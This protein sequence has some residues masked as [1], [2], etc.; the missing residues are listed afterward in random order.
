M[1]DILKRLK[2]WESEKYDKRKIYRNTLAGG[3]PIAVRALPPI[4]GIVGSRFDIYKVPVGHYLLLLHASILNTGAGAQIWLDF[5]PPGFPE[6][7]IT[8]PLAGG[9]ASPSGCIFLMLDNVNMAQSQGITLKRN[10]IIPELSVIRCVKNGSSIPLNDLII[11]LFGLLY[12]NSD[13]PLINALL[14]D[15][16]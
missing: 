6:L 7:P 4:A 16:A 8:F 3:N 11:H 13:T 9:S 5:V 12:P 2:F 10:V 1:T 14:A 15:E